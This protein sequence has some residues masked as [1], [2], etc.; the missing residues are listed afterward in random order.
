MWHSQGMVIGKYTCISSEQNVVSIYRPVSPTCV[1]CKLLKTLFVEKARV[2]GNNELLS[3]RQHACRTDNMRLGKLTWSTSIVRSRDWSYQLWGLL[4]DFPWT[5]TGNQIRVLYIFA[6]AI[7]LALTS[8]CKTML[9]RNSNFYLKQ[10]S[11]FFSKTHQKQQIQVN[12]LDYVS[13]TVRR[14]PVSWESSNQIVQ[15][16][17][18]ELQ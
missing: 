18:F 8:P 9:I 13:W 5:L 6:H 7:F 17:I 12:I 15:M 4:K 1:S 16:H 2:T 11:V 10:S 14:S 3:N